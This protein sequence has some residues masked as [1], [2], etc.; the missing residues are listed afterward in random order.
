MSAF[1]LRIRIYPLKSGCGAD[2]AQAYLA[3]DGFIHD[4]DWLLVEPEG[5]FMSQ[6]NFPRMAL[7]CPSLEQSQALGMMRHGGVLVVNAPHMPNLRVRFYTVRDDYDVFREV[8]IHGDTG[9]G[10]DVGSEAADWF[11]E[12]LE[13][14]CALVRMVHHSRTHHSSVLQ[15]SFEVRGQ[16]GYPVHLLGV[17]SCDDL[18]RRASRHT[19]HENFRANLMIAGTEP[20]EEDTWVGKRI[21]I[22]RAVMRVVKTNQRCPI[23]TVNQAN[24]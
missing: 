19:P 24:G 12:F 9:L 3:N 20:Y 6:R 23:P 21:R 14:P 15:K 22:G 4:R 8:H 13:T 11:S 2:V 16:D 10:Y 7:I 18:D 17:A 1:V 5:T